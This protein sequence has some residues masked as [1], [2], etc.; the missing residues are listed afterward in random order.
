MC[1]KQIRKTGRRVQLHDVNT[2]R[3]KYR[4]NDGAGQNVQAA[5]ARTC[6]EGGIASVVH[7][8]L[9][10]F[11][12]GSINFSHWLSFQMQPHDCLA[13]REVFVVFLVAVS[14]VQRLHGLEGVL[15]NRRSAREG[16]EGWD[17]QTGV[18]RRTGG[19][20]QNI[21]VSRSLC[22]YYRSIHDALT[23]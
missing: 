2:V 17:V 12:M 21:I 23:M 7:L 8:G 5:D 19:G 3:G 11:S 1:S 10:R 16:G 9:S 6:S 4:E 20:R 14:R 13:D 15:V 22:L 18:R